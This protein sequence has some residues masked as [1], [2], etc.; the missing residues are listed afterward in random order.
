M[1]QTKQK[2]DDM[3]R[4]YWMRIMS[5]NIRTKT[6]YNWDNVFLCTPIPW[7]ITFPFEY[8][9]LDI[10]EF[11]TI[12]LPNI[13]ILSPQQWES[14]QQTTWVAVCSRVGSLPDSY[15]YWILGPMAGLF[16]QKYLEE[17]HPPKTTMY[18]VG[19]IH[20]QGPCGVCNMTGEVYI[21]TFIT[22]G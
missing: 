16:E 12:P 18:A 6:L 11:G 9:L 20:F 17:S 2:W 1:I 13:R 14:N 22:G 7:L 5:V 19:S 10:K 3:I 15:C 4:W 8:W 21:S